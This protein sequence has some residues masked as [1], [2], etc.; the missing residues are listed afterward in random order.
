MVSPSGEIKNDT[1]LSYKQPSFNVHI[2]TQVFF[3]PDIRQN[4]QVVTFHF[5]LKSLTV[6]TPSDFHAN[7]SFG[8][9]VMYCELG[10]VLSFYF[11]VS[12]MAVQ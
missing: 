11:S 6:F 7:E 4:F 9:C 3:L 10:S 5:N 1:I 12:N 2:L 8:W